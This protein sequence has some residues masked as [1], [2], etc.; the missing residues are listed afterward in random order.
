[1]DDYSVAAEPALAG[2]SA[3]RVGAFA[4]HQFAS[5]EGGT[6]QRNRLHAAA[7]RENAAIGGAANS[8]GLRCVGGNWIFRELIS[9]H[10]ALLVEPGLSAGLGIDAAVCA[11]RLHLSPNALS[12]RG[13]KRRTSQTTAAHQSGDFG[14]GVRLRF[15][16][17][18]ELGADVFDSD[19][20][21]VLVL[22]VRTCAE[23][24]GAWIVARDHQP[25]ADD[26]VATVAAAEHERGL[27]T[28]SLSKVLTLYG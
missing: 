1:M 25:D 13:R 15:S 16:A 28:F 5:R 17:C 12:V 24:V 10:I 11:A 3:G 20:R 7:F 8:G 4:D 22:G 18:S 14:H 6:P 26:R 27:Q 23:S 21:I 9:S 2:G 19:W